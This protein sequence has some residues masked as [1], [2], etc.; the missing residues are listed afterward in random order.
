MLALSLG[1]PPAFALDPDNVWHDDVGAAQRRLDSAQKR[2]STVLS[3][4][5][6]ARTELPTVRDGA[7]HWEAVLHRREA[8]AQAALG[9]ARTA[10]QRVREDRRAAFTRSAAV[11]SAYVARVGGWREA[12]SRRIAIAWMLLAVIGGLG[13]AAVGSRTAAS[14]SGEDESAEHRNRIV[15]RAAILFGTTVALFLA[16]LVAA[17]W[18]ADA[19]TF[20]WWEVGAAVACGLLP[21]GLFVGWW[22][23]PD[24][25]EPLQGVARRLAPRLVVAATLLASFVVFAGTLSTAAPQARSLPEVQVRLARA[26]VSDVKTMACT[27]PGAM[28]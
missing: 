12:R 21:L 4:A 27:G 18:L 1:V 15:R 24:P 17:L 8:R 10:E 28:A 2:L 26:H 13:M 16:S 20:S 7:S 25:S 19:W 5:S 11:R 14:S 3:G 9:L 6:D 22:R 23:S